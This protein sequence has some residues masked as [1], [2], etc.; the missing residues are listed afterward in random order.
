MKFAPRRKAVHGPSQLQARL[1]CTRLPA[2]PC[3]HLALYEAMTD[4]GDGMLWA[5]SEH[6]RLRA[7]GLAR[8]GA[9]RCPRR[10][11]A[12]PTPRANAGDEGV[13]RHEE[14]RLCARPEERSWHPGHCPGELSRTL[15]LRALPAVFEPYLMPMNPALCV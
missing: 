13:D 3:G 9:V 1:L 11:R 4:P 12:A 7:P 10:R 5:R 2:R 8:V 14:L 15:L 6:P